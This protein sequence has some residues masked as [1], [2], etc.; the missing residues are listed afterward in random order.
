LKKPTQLFSKFPNL[1]FFSPISGS[2]WWRNNAPQEL[3]KG[4]GIKKLNGLVSAA[5]QKWVRTDTEAPSFL[6]DSFKFSP[7]S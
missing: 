7:I 5:A 4:P 3:Q 1:T 6:A 2:T